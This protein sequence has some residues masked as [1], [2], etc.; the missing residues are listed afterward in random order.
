MD[1]RLKKAS[2]SGDIDFLYRLIMEDGE[3]LDHLTGASFVDTPLHIAAAEGHTQFAMEIMR[4]K[5]SFARKPN[6]DGFSPMHLALQ[7]GKTRMVV[8]LLDAD[9]SL[10]RVP[11]R[12]GVTPLHYV[13]KEGNIGLLEVFLSACPK[14]LEDV[15]IRNETSLHIA[16]KN[17]KVEAFEFVLRWLKEVCY[18]EVHQ[19]EKKVLNWKDEDGNTLLHIATLRNQPQAVMLLLTS[20]V[21]VNF[22]NLAGWTPLDI[23]QHQQ[24]L[25][26]RQIRTTLCG[27]GALEGSSLLSVPTFS[28]D[29]RLKQAAQ[30]GNIGGL[31]ALLQED[32][33]ILERINLVPFVDTPLHIA[34][35]SGHTDFAMEMMRLKPEFARKQNPEGF[36]AMHLA[37]KQGKT[38]T[39]LFLLSIYRDLVRVKGREGKTL[40]H[41][42]AEIGNFDL[43]AEFLAASP[44]SIIDLTIRK[45][46]ALHIAAKNDKL[47]ALEVL[48]GWLHHVAMDMILQWTDDEGNTVVRLLIKRVDINAKNLEGLTAMDISDRQGMLNNNTEIRSLLLQRG[49]LTASSL[50]KLP[51]LANFLRTEMSLLE[52]WVMCSYLTKSCLSNENR[53][54]LLVVAVLIAT[55]TFQAV[56]SPP[57][58]MQI[59]ST[60]FGR[61]TSSDG[62]N[63]TG[64]PDVPSN[65]ASHFVVAWS[66]FLAMN[67]MAFLTSI[68]EIWFHLPRGLYFLTKLVLPLL[69]CYMISLSLTTPV[70]SVTPFYFALIFFSQLKRIVG[71]LFFKR[72]LDVKLSLL[73]YCPNLHREIKA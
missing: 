1:Q 12:E 57:A 29:Q 39:L 34:A 46:T 19:L 64:E 37:L 58:G 14:S 20:Q 9:R 65:F 54:N 6:Q 48:M 72:S 2:Q 41:C 21:D 68:S 11:G 42:A 44:E 7:S 5:P 28:T 24:P 49:A 71:N 45:E 69:F 67:T 73:K 27:A 31:Y 8:R 35:S 50:P 63:S 33:Y 66:S 62:S 56:L 23:I 15:T 25:N 3:L 55:A 30:G 47:E 59:F 52:R 17:D 32:S 4:L 53:N 43:L 13:A 60:P 36:S 40:L 38:Q 18:E 26:D 22:K 70:P 51:T 61:K 10:V 16:L